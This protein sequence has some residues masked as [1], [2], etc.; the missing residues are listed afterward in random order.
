M[1]TL[2]L[3]IVEGRDFDK[4]FSTDSTAVIVNQAFL[5]RFGITDPL[6]KTIAEHLFNNIPSG[7]SD[8]SPYKLKVIGVVKDVNLESLHNKMQETIY[9]LQSDFGYRFIILRVSAINIRETLSLLEKTWKDIQLDKPF[10]YYFQD[11][12]L[13]KQYAAEIKWSVIIRCSA[14]LA[15]L[16]ACM[17]IF[18][19]TAITIRRRLKEIGIRKVLGAKVTQIVNMILKDYIVIVVVSNS[20]AW[21]VVYFVMQRVLRNYAYRIDIT[22]HYFL[23]AAAASL[24][25]AVLT[26]MYLAVKAA[27][28]NPVETLR[29]E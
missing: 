13:E 29:D 1:K 28:A 16:L 17:G 18:G 12:I 21:P 11:E 27:F 5:K 22:V 2:G 15:S 3:G 9:H 20:I 23:L 10:V 6:G 14:V 25:I 4:G 7:F 19:L 24:S 26:I 8:R